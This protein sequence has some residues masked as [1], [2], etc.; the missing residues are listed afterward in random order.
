MEYNEEIAV[1]KLYRII[2]AVSNLNFGALSGRE[3]FF[4]YFAGYCPAENIFNLRSMRATLR[5]VANSIQRAED[6]VLERSLVIIVLFFFFSSM[7][8][9]VRV[10]LSRCR[11]AAS[12]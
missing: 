9:F 8:N 10:S 1:S 5:R 11:A 2:K 12:S 4:P 7:R 3:Y 6:F